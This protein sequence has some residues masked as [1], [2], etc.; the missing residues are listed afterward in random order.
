MEL[1]RLQDLI[2]GQLDGE[3]SAGERAELARLVLEDAEARRLHDEYLRSDRLLRNIPAA[4]P[5]PGLRE[6]IQAASARTDRPG[7][8]ASRWWRPS[9]Y[10]IA[11]AIVVG[12]VVVG[13]AYLVR[14]GHA[15]GTD[16]Q[17]SLRDARDP[18]QAVLTLRGE[19]VTV[20][21][22][23]RRAGEGL[24]LELG[25]SASDSCEI[26]VRIDPA[27]TTFAGSDGD[28][29]LARAGDQVTAR[30]SAGSRVTVLEFSGAGPMQLELRAAG[31]LL[32]SGKL[33]VS[34]P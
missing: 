28:A 23:L 25:S 34:D 19:G 7:D 3:L 33:S 18:Q 4:E 14:D 31:R 21:A 11:A 24:R 8:A 9:T 5:P 29:S 10:R 15:P 26:A 20:N 1:A 2:Q 22:S 32:D 12:L 17:G 13:V 16:L 6:A 27:R 30:L